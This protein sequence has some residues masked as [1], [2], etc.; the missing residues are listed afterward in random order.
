[1]PACVTCDAEA[2]RVLDVFDRCVLCSDIEGYDGPLTSPSG[3][4]IGTVCHPICGDGIL[5]GAES[6]DDGNIENGDGCSS[7]C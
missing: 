2:G 3:T 5:L 7:I 1:M 4:T 6:C